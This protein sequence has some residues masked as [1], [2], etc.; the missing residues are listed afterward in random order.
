MSCSKALLKLT[1]DSQCTLGMLGVVCETVNGKQSASRQYMSRILGMGTVLNRP[2]LTIQDE[3]YCN[4]LSAAWLVVRH[5]EEHRGCEDCSC[6]MTGGN[7]G[8]VWDGLV[9]QSPKI[10]L[11]VS[12]ELK[13]RQNRMCCSRHSFMNDLKLSRCHCPRLSTR[14][15]TRSNHLSLAAMPMTDI[16]LE[17][18]ESMFSTFTLALSDP[19]QQS[20]DPAHMS[21]AAEM[22]PPLPDEVGDIDFS[23]G[24]NE[25]EALGKHGDFAMNDQL[26]AQTHEIPMK[27]ATVM[28]RVLAPNKEFL[29]AHRG[30]SPLQGRTEKR[31][32][33]LFC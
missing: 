29:I 27:P 8:D 11:L 16:D 20:S 4:R 25:K 9:L 18:R 17:E 23:D 15:H 28:E 26:A 32:T 7:K 6:G 10:A 12:S 1:E 24:C 13:G 3:Q 19:L 30:P 31:Y 14:C 21:A 33:S 22:E 2:P 5:Q